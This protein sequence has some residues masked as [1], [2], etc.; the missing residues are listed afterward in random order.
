[1]VLRV[2]EAFDLLFKPVAE[3]RATKSGWPDYDDRRWFRRPPVPNLG[4]DLEALADLD[5]KEGELVLMQRIQE[6][7]PHW[8]KRWK[9]E[10]ATATER[11]S[12]TKPSLRAK[13]RGGLDERRHLP[14]RSPYDVFAIPAYLIDAAGVYH[15]SQPEK[16]NGC[17]GPCAFPS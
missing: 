16:R 11:I 6:A 7:L 4:E 15:P 3:E 12:A 13:L 8:R 10:I 14:P 2:S 5:A 9:S 1:M 17:S